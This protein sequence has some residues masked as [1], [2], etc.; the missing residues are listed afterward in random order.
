MMAITLV[1]TLIILRC[2]A[3]L[4]SPISSLQSDLLHGFPA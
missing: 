2:L 3:Q 4:R 1:A